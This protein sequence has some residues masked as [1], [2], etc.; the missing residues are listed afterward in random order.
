MAFK[1]VSTVIID[2]KKWP[3]APLTGYYLGSTSYVDP[4]YNKTQF[5]HSFRKEAGEEVSV[6]GFT[7]LDTRM[8]KVERGVLCQVTYKGTE[9][10]QTKKYGLKDV[11]QAEVLQDTDRR[12]EVDHIADPEND[13]V[14]QHA[15]AAKAPDALPAQ[16]AAKGKAVKPAAKTPVDDD[17]PPF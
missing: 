6:Y 5:V 12:I 7:T 4:T 3:N 8:A 1:E 11:H 9:Q 13:P 16:S 15:P 14:T 10:V 17:I 2:L